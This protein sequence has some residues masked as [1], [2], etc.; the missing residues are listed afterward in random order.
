[1]G[2]WRSVPALGPGDA[3][4]SVELDDADR[5]NRADRLKSLVSSDNTRLRARI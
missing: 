4:R 5:E 1:L 3:L 2:N